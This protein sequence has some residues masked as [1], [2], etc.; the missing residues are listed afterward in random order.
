MS[1]EKPVVTLQ[2]IFIKMIFYI[3]TEFTQGD[4]L[5]W[6]E[7]IPGRDPISDIL[8][9]FIVGREAKLTVTANGGISGF[10]FSIASATTQALQPGKYKAQFAIFEPSGNKTTLGT[11]KLIV[12]PSFENLTELETRSS[13]EIELELIT[14]AIAKLASGA[15]AEY[16]IGD[17]MMRYTDLGELTKRQQYL[18]TR[19]AMANGKIKPGS[20]NI[21]VRFSS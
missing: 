18:R 12:L 20:R 19:V 21:G 16:R 11:T 17:R 3:P 6:Y 8:K 7:H 5:S 13:D 9:V 14:K 2:P 15:V 10:E 1:S 4:R